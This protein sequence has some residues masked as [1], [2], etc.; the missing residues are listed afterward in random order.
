MPV[1]RITRGLTWSDLHATLVGRGLLGSDGSR[2]GVRPPPCRNRARFP[3]VA[4]GHV[5]VAP[6]ARTQTYSFA[7]QAVERGAS[8]RVRAAAPDLA[9]AVGVSD[10]R[11]ALAVSRRSSNVTEPRCVIGI[12]GTNGKTTTA[13][14]SRPSSR[15][16][17]PC[18][19]WTVAR[20]GARFA[21]PS[22][23]RPRRRTFSG[24]WV[25]WW[26]A[27]AAP[28]RW[29]FVHALS[30]SRGPH[31]LPVSSPTLRAIT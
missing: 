31:S 6:K 29:S 12:T 18:E 21:S 10:A 27:G 4:A 19:R 16:P 26:I 25:K 11:L 24:P 7:R 23:P 13:H 1:T 9:G 17:A 14:P 2:A 20:I 15:P 28:A 8:D 30:L 22:G 5:F 3:T